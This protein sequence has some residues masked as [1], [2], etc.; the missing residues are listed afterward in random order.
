MF[1]GGALCSS[2]LYKKPDAVGCAAETECT[3]E[4]ES[5][6]EFQET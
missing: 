6:A 1:G 3:A 2:A 5:T 4:R